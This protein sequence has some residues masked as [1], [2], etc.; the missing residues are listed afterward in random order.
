MET[1]NCQNCKKDFQIE[2]EDFDFYKKIK[3]PP[4]TFCVDCREQ[5]RIAYRNE[6]IFYKRNCDLCG[7]SVVSRVSPDK[8]YPMYCT[9]CWW[10]DKW[11]VYSYGRDYDFSKPFFQQW[12][13]LYFSVP[14]V[15]MFN[16]NSINSDWINQES[17]DKNCYLNVG[18]HYNEDSAYNTYELQ[19][20]NC[21]DNYWILDCDHCSNSI[22]CERN[23]FSNFC[24][25]CHDCLYSNFSYDCRN[26]SHIVGCAGLRN[27]K[28]CILNVQ[29][30]KEEYE[31]FIKE[32][33]LSSN[34]FINWWS[35]ES[36]KVWDK[37]PHRENFIFKSVNSSGNYLAEAKNAINCWNGTKLENC[38]NMFITGWMK[39]S[40]DCSS[41][42]ASEL[43]YECAHSG[44]S[45][46]SRALLFC[47]SSD[48]LK[49]ITIH[50]VEYSTNTV[51]SSNCFGCSGIRGG[52]YV[53]L[54]RR[55][56]KEEYEEI[57][58]KIKKHMIEMP[59]IDSLG[60][61]YG[62]GEFFPSE[63]SPFGY[64][65]TIAQEYF[66]MTKDDAKEQGFTW[67]D[68]ESDTHYTFSDYKIPVD[69]KDVGDDIL[70]MILKCEKSGK[71]YKIIPMEL[72]F[73]REVG[74]PI[75]RLSPQERHISRM[76]ELLPRKLFERNC[77][78]CNKVIHTSYSKERPQIIYCEECYQKEVL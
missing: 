29:Y 31:K 6:R 68:F 18:G 74:I 25:E 15:S 72:S 59:Y 48:P 14:H 17:D 43:A 42:G 26:C 64:N 65:E 66:P 21:F 62:Y 52:E 53:I 35:V 10:S 8:K 30:T 1:K 24:E 2:S 32:H 3:V 57:L 28:Y 60:R 45:Y 37:S 19:G 71:A 69:I 12:K 9:K 41:V 23:Y 78:N 50:N 34:D 54:N 63:L 22:N 76:K 39:D 16:S 13:E 38:K 55:Y 4:P 40:Y 44:G 27:K 49:K 51:S 77:M 70:K 75:P 56:T 5:R 61:K 36:K 33:P 73:Y 11:D 46:N 67:S 7:E 58:P 47:L 20:K